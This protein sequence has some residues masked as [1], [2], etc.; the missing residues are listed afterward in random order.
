M[1]LDPR[2][3]AAL[4]SGAK[5]S[6]T[7]DPSKLTSGGDN[8]KSGAW[9]L[10]QFAIDVLSTG[11][12]ATAGLTSKLGQNVAAIGRGEAGG[13]LDFLNPFSGLNAAVEG[14]ASRR[15]YSDNLKDMG[16]Q[17]PTATWLGL[18][19]D[20]GLDPTTYITG[21]AIAGAR[22]AA[23]GAKVGA[24]ATK[25][26]KIAATP[27]AKALETFV[28][29]GRPLTQSEKIGNLVTG[30]NKG[31]ETGKSTYKL[32]IKGNKLTRVT[33]RQTKKMETVRGDVAIDPTFIAPVAKAAEKQAKAAERAAQ[34]MPEIVNTKVVQKDLH[35]FAE[36][37]NSQGIITSW[38]KANKAYTRKSDATK[39]A[40]AGRKEVEDAFLAGKT[41]DIQTNPAAAVAADDIAVGA[42]R[43]DEAGADTIRQREV[44]ADGSK[45]K[46]S[47][48]KLAQTLS[49]PTSVRAVR[50]IN[51]TV[52]SLQETVKN[53]KGQQLE[54][55]KAELAKAE[56]ELAKFDEL[57]TNFYDRIED[58]KQFEETRVSAS[59]IEKV[60]VQDIVKYINQSSKTAKADAVIDDILF[61]SVDVPE[62]AKALRNALD[63]A[64]VDADSAKLEDL[65]YLIDEGTATPAVVAKATALAD[66]TIDGAAKNAGLENPE[67]F[68]WTDGVV[69]PEDAGGAIKSLV[70]F[71]YSDLKKT[72]VAY[73][74]IVKALEDAYFNRL[75]AVAGGADRPL[76]SLE[77]EEVF[78]AFLAGTDI[79]KALNK[80]GA[81][82]LA[83]IDPGTYNSIDELALDLQEGRLTLS[84]IQKQDLSEILGVPKDNVQASVAKVLNNPN[85][86]SNVLDGA[87]D[88]VELS[89]VPITAA[90]AIT[91]TG[92][93]SGPDVAILAAASF[94]PEVETAFTAAREAFGAEFIASVKVLEKLTG[95]SERAVKSKIAE[96]FRDF[97]LPSV[98]AQIKALVPAGKTLDE[99]IEEALTGKV[100]VLTED[101]GKFTQNGAVKI[102][103]FGTHGRI[104]MYKRVTNA[105]LYK[106]LSADEIASR[107]SAYFLAIENFIRTLG[108]PVRSTETAASALA[109]SN[110]KAGSKK[111]KTIP[112]EYSSV[113]WADI[114]G[115]MQ[116]KGS[117]KLVGELR[118]IRGKD[119]EAYG[120]GNFVPTSIEAAWLAVKR[121]KNNG[122][123]ITRG[124]D[125]FLEV[126]R[127]LDSDFEKGG[128]VA[129][130]ANHVKTA[131]ALGGKSAAEINKASDD[132]IEFLSENFDDLKLLDDKRE[133]LLVAASARGAWGPASEVFLALAKF[134]NEYQTMRRAH[135]SGDSSTAQVEEKIGEIVA[136]YNNL[137]TRV[138]VGDFGDQDLASSVVSVIKNGFLQGRFTP[139]GVEQASLAPFAKE[140][141]NV[142]K[143]TRAMDSAAD[144]PAQLNAR[145]IGKAASTGD[146]VSIAS[147]QFAKAAQ[148]GTPPPVAS[149]AS[150]TA[151]QEA[152]MQNKLFGKM[153]GWFTGLNK[154]LN[155]NYVMGAPGKTLISSSEQSAIGYSHLFALGLKEM[156]KVTKG[157]EAD[158]TKAFAA[159][160]DYRKAIDE[161]LE[162]GDEIIEIDDFLAGY[163]GTVDREFFRLIDDS[164]EVLLGND[165]VFGAAKNLGVMPAELNRSLRQ[166]GLKSIEVGDEPIESFWHK[167]NL[168][169]L[170]N[171]PL[172]FLNLLNLAVHR[173][174]SRVEIA[175][176]LDY[177]VGKTAAQIAEAGDDIS[178]YVKLPEGGTFS[179]IL[180]ETGKLVHKD[181]L[182]R[183]K[184]MEEY[185]DTDSAFSDGAL[186]RIVE[187]SDRITYVLKSSNTLIRPGHH[188]VSIV[189]EYAMN[190]LAGVRH[191]S[192]NNT[193][194]IMNKYR[195]GQYANEGE[196]FKAYA[197]L[198][199]TKG[200][201]IK[202]DEFDNVYWIQ[203]GKKVVIPDELV[204]S[205]AER[206]GVLV[207][208][209]GSLEDFIVTGEP[210][211]KGSYAK[212]HQGMNKIAVFAS[213]RDNFFRLTHF[214][215]E[216]SRT[217]G[218][219]TIDEA[220]LAAGTAI[221]QWHP[222]T[223]S[224]SAFE[225]KY[226]R[227]LVYFYTWQRVALTK[228]IGTM[229][230]KPGIV[231]IP[232]KVQYA[233]QDANGFNPESFGDPWDPDGIYASWHTGQLWGPQFQ[234]PGGQGDAW[235]IQP[236]IQ[237]IDVIGQFF[238]P[239]TLQ[240]GQSPLTSMAQ[241]A[242]DLVGSNFNPL[243]KTFIESSAQSRLGDGG[244]LPS[245]TEY[246]VNQ[247]GLINTLSKVS[248]VGQDENPYETEREKTEKDTRAWLNLILGQRVQ[249]YSTP[250][251]QYKW[252]LDQQEAARR[253]A[254]Q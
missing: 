127:T 190:L 179:E 77:V 246:L 165:N 15:T 171:S 107:E 99:F 222:T 65:I 56:T 232:S 172:E 156:K 163:S 19:L 150:D 68:P 32:S 66:S 54:K 196:P 188:V 148:A 129:K 35:F 12:Y 121:I 237:P 230:E 74:A 192:Y 28:P 50:D 189:G 223:G 27:S 248:G 116:A 245:P 199:A 155:G 25:A 60:S 152:V 81:V 26:G 55:A 227:R 30:I 197:E 6:G 164:L 251:T 17:G 154:A 205:L 34:G 217:T 243:I 115:L 120:L 51:R 31:Y 48:N 46:N 94:T 161:I 124:S 241:G 195:P 168:E 98:V 176:Q 20:I 42:V 85:G 91:A 8:E 109:R 220:A 102:D 202:A 233:L 169:E 111:A 182:P 38:S 142:L 224:L 178:E 103:E 198:T 177:F 86:V 191:S 118:K 22:M 117:A 9:N 203:N 10:G 136:D 139:R 193:A 133:D 240:P 16:V 57:K 231:T 83:K 40:K 5:T 228:V 145:R 21:G 157:R 137:L 146:D 244:D 4:S 249:D 144:L 242:G 126:R 206:Y 105:R 207:H 112:S 234:G 72:S 162:A 170:D 45:T 44:I 215:D 201:R 125:D 175:S 100:S 212:F 43:G 122:G 221:R 204:Y 29:A 108:I 3:I 73:K 104:D 58:L 87:A 11:G 158:L 247:V 173:S 236:A 14:V 134:S 1:A 37:S 214:I 140:I 186:R 90:D 70:D 52:E 167:V 63:E 2:V 128:V 147:E 180:G 64:G 24:Q 123:D 153:Q 216:L 36:I 174:A 184:A 213:H 41:P 23:R 225:R 92:N 252:S 76:T 250:S 235:G 106:K 61:E 219:K 49:K 130:E 96:I 200:K 101:L 95:E 71:V 135:K 194:R 89:R 141:E 166:L 211:I 114:V 67:L 159:V 160:Q 239:F 238:K 97:M 78:E 84:N 53:A 39:A 110:V 143:T 218:A 183:I 209:G 151:V 62:S 254:G 132:L 82:D 229:L 119:V 69:T 208:P 13:A 93:S 88:A 210:I 59:K 18:A 185:M 181:E 47:L 226:M 33:R 75:K 7:F 187:M 79:S 138:A 113:T 253:L 80:V 131:E 149:E